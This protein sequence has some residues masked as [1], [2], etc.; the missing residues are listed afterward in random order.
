M[1]NLLCLVILV[2]SLFCKA[3]NIEKCTVFQYSGNDSLK[4]HIARIQIYN[5]HGLIEMET[6]TNYKTSINGGYRDGT[7]HY[8]YMDT[9]LY[10]RV[11]IDDNQDTLKT[12]YLYNEKNQIIKE[13]Y[14]ESKKELRKDAS[15]GCVHFEKD[16]E[17]FRT[18]MKISEVNYT[19]DEKGRKV[20]KVEENNYTRV[21]EYDSI[22]RIKLE[23]GYSGNQLSY[24]EKY[25]YFKDSFK[26]STIQYDSDGNPK[27]ALYSDIFFQPIFTTTNYLNT[28]GQ[29]IKTETTT[30]KNIIIG[31]EITEY[32]SNGKIRKTIHTTIDKHYLDSNSSP[33]ITHIFE[34]D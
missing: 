27:P 25:L 8:Y 26:F 11:F 31:N 29:I 6:Y 19:Y 24:M 13:E 32:Y 5:T 16:F 10:K 3:Q 34:Y 18:W 23:M 9:L 12:L 4:K 15:K 21:W 30:E 28:K 22:S 20:K 1:K 14:F 33:V 7:Y 17:L 2:S